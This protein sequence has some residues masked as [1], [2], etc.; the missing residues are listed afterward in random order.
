MMYCLGSAIRSTGWQHLTC[1]WQGWK[2]QH[3]KAHSRATE[4]VSARRSTGL[5][6]AGLPSPDIVSCCNKARR[7]GFALCF[8]F[9]FFFPVDQV[10]PRAIIKR[11]SWI[12][13]KQ[14]KGDLNHLVGMVEDPLIY[15][16]LLLLMRRRKRKK[17]RSFK[18]PR[19]T[20]QIM[21]YLQTLFQLHNC[22]GVCMCAASLWEG[23]SAGELMVLQSYKTI[24]LH[25]SRPVE[26]LYKQW[27]LAE[28]SFLKDCWMWTSTHPVLHQAV[29]P[30]VQFWN[31]SGQFITCPNDP[32][33]WWVHLHGT[34]TSISSPRS[35]NKQP[36][37]FTNP[38][39]K[40]CSFSSNAQKNKIIFIPG[41]PTCFLDIKMS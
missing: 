22:C 41:S 35:S 10:C 40:Y 18:Q 21:F 6:P 26:M 12:L 16:P 2:K 31:Y 37:L 29:F 7:F 11:V 39:A 13:T 30:E 28:G 15:E 5:L 3:W 33:T 1:G 23:N 25:S 27:K 19:P 4:V 36:F 32:V 17:K 34:C 8:V 14:S 20:R 24:C 38:P 9:V